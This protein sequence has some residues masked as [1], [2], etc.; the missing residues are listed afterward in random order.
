MILAIMS[1]TICA[2]LRC[3][4]SSLFMPLGS[5]GGTGG[6]RF[7]IH[8]EMKTARKSSIVSHSQKLPIT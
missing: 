7:P 6:F 5:P 1:R 3:Q 4:G 2:L 8:G